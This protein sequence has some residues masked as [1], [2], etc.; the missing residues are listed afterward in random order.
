MSLL[1]LLACQRNA[2]AGARDAV[3]RGSRLAQQP[4]RKHS[5]QALGAD[6]GQDDGGGAP[7]QQHPQPQP[8]TCR[9]WPQEAADAKDCH[10][11]ADSKVGGLMYMKI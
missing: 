10:L 2:A 8:P 6:D 4:G 5:A 11:R 3:R 7:Q 9:P 1:L